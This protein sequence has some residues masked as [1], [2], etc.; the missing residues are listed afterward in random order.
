MPVA[1][2]CTQLESPTLV[3]PLAT[4]VIIK[5]PTKVPKIEPCPPFKLA[6][7]ITTAAIMS[8]SVPLVVVGSPSVR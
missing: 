7:P 8:N 1:I 4:V 6:P 3:Q 2:S 5:A